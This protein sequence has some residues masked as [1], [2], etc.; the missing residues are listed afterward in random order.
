MVFP[1]GSVDKESACNVEDP[2]LIPRLGRSGEGNGNPLEYYWAS[3]AAQMVKF[4][5]AMW[6]TQI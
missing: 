3:Q 5:H 2:G 1:R 6:E 4:L